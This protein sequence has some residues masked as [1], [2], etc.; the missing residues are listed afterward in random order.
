MKN[1][2]AIILSITIFCSCAHLPCGSPAQVEKWNNKTKFRSA[3]IIDKIK[4]DGQV[5]KVKFKK[6][7]ALQPTYNVFAYECLPD[8]FRV[9]KE[10]NL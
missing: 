6:K 4:F 7:T 8:S 2:I 3:W 9:G 1:I 10:V 5:Y